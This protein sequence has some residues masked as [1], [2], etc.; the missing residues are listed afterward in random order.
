MSR[1]CEAALRVWA[2]STNNN[3]YNNF[4]TIGLEGTNN[5]NNANNLFAV[6]FGFCR[7]LC[8]TVMI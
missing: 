8:F 5:N 3:N 7:Q 4:I 1:R 6:L 2:A